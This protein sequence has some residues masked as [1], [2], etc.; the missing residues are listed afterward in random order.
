MED[1]LEHIQHFLQGNHFTLQNNIRLESA[2]PDHA[3]FSLEIQPA[4]C[5]SYGQVHGG[6]IY[7]M[8][9]N[10]AGVA[11]MSDG[12]FYVTQAGTLHFLHNQSS[13][14]IL[15]SAQVRHR[16]RQLCLVD[17]SITGESGHL[18]ATGEFTFFC[19]NQKYSQ[20]HTHKP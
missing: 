17:V 2:Q 13:G 18:L 11:A 3:S 16:G 4:C 20:P 19:L 1:L 15:A 8:A 9:D 6:A 12:R 7:T 14:T 5:N 10:A